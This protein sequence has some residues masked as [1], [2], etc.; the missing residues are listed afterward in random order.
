MAVSV[1]VYGT[2]ITPSADLVTTLLSVTL[3]V[4]LS[5]FSVSF[6][7]VPVVVPIDALSCETADD[8]LVPHADV[9]STESRFK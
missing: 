5:S 8:L 7:S 6:Q 2:V 3:I 9:K 4:F 1:Y